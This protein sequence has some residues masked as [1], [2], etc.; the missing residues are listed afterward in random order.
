MTYDEKFLHG[1]KIAAVEI[2][3]PHCVPA[4]MYDALLQAYDHLQAE[5]VPLHQEIRRL[6]ES[7]NR[8]RAVAIVA[9]MVAA[10]AVGVSR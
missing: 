8:W 7:R 3:H 10:F 1:V 5:A 2:P 6:E 4:P 9:L